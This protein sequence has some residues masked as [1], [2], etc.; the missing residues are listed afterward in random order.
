MHSIPPSQQK[1][2]VVGRKQL[3]KSA[4]RSHVYLRR[5]LAFPTGKPVNPRNFYTTPG[6][7]SMKDKLNITGNKS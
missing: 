1:T 5:S 7:G 4:D 6:T 3:G 2:V